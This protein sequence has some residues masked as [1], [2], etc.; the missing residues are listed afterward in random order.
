MNRSM[1]RTVGFTVTAFLCW[2]GA[3]SAAQITAT[4]G[5]QPNA[6]VQSGSP[7][8]GTFDL[9]SW[10]DDY[11]LSD[12]SINFQFRDDNDAVLTSQNITSSYA[13]SGV[14]TYV[15]RHYYSCGFS[16][17][18]RDYYSY[19]RSYVR[20]GTEAWSDEP[21][22]AYLT[23]GGEEFSASSTWF[24]QSQTPRLFDERVTS[25][26]TGASHYDS[27]Y[28]EWERTT[29][30]YRGLFSISEPLGEEALLTLL[31]DG[32]LSYSVAA[33]SDFRFLGA[34]L[35]FTATSSAPDAMP[36]PA[37]LALL[38]LGLAGLGLMRRRR[39]N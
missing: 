17:C 10:L 3:A 15:D 28:T 35:T 16:T 8:T 14:E 25:H 9:T 11:A 26:S 24:R 2:Q 32:L 29:T 23:I 5:S 36:E 7:M 38:G 21:E 13:L 30:G 37:A 18:Y 22:T 34:E 27:Y 6:L 39:G 19:Y 33:G 4:V 12:L 20:T 31:D 1:A